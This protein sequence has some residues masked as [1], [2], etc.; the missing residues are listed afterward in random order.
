MTN[1]PGCIFCQIIAGDAPSQMVYRDEVCVA[2]MDINPATDGHTLIVTTDH[3]PTLFDL[4]EEAQR[5][6]VVVASL[7]AK[8][9][10]E[11]LEPDGMNMFQANGAAAFQTVDHFHLHLVPRWFGD[12]IQVPWIPTPGDPER[13]KRNAERLKEALAGS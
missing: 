7:V 6:L 4:S 5:S 2:F 8:G 3:F 11:C 10:K 12:P 1:D 13:I 9:L